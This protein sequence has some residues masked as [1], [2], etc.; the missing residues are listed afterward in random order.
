MLTPHR[1]LPIVHAD[2]P[3]LCARKPHLVSRF[4]CRPTT[5][6]LC[7]DNN[8]AS[9]LG[10]SSVLHQVMYYILGRSYHSWGGHRSCIPGRSSWGGHRSYIPGGH[11]GA[12]IG[13]T[14]RAV[15][16]GWSS[17]LHPGAVIGLASGNVLHP[18]RS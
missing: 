1:W 13:L 17:V 9:I 4:G 5:A 6:S 2:W 16:L 11:P 10:R 12:V 18:G 8:G 3:R 14:S 15:I 7:T